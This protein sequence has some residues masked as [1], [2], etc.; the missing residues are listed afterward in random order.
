MLF[1]SHAGALAAELSK[2]MSSV[3][4]SSDPSALFNQTKDEYVTP[5][6]IEGATRLAFTRAFGDPA[7]LQVHLRAGD[8]A[9]LVAEGWEVGNHT[10]GHDNLSQL[11]RGGVAESI[12]L[13]ERYWGARGLRLLR[14]VAVPNGAARHVGPAFRSYLDEHADLHAM[15]C[16]GGVNFRPSRTEWLRIPMSV[17]PAAELARRMSVEADR[18]REASKAINDAR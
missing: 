7:A 5:G 14:C 18:S 10:Y 3:S 12:E 8:V 11:D 17:Q 9:A 4:W 6:L 16:N 2:R 15:F 13:N 1:R